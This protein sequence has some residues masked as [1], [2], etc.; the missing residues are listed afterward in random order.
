MEAASPRLV[1]SGSGRIALTPEMDAELD[2]AVRRHVA[3]SVRPL[4]RAAA[5]AVHHRRRRRHHPRRRRAG[6]RRSP[7]GRGARREPRPEA[8]RLPRCSNTGPDRPLAEP[9]RARRSTSSSLT[10]E[11]TELQLQGQ[12]AFDQNELVGPGVRRRATS[13][14]LQGFYRDL[15]S[16][17]TAALKAQISGPL[18]KPVFSGSAD[19][20]DGRLRAAVGAATR[21]RRSTA[22]FRSTPAA[23]GS[24]TWRRGSAKGTCG[25]ADASGSTASR[26]AT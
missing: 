15:R 26:S 5:V 22:G 7:R 10:G 17:G 16:R 3:R 8:V 20:T 9:A 4:L 6:R 23:F 14:I 1:V 24:T 19:V 2:A 12:V 11:G 18:D 25:S 13:G 21:S